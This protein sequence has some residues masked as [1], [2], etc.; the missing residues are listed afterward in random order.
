MGDCTFNTNP[1][2]IQEGHKACALSDNGVDYQQGMSNTND[3]IPFNN[4]KDYGLKTGMGTGDGGYENRAEDWIKNAGGASDRY[5]YTDAMKDLFAWPNSADVLRPGTHPNNR[6]NP[7]DD[8]ADGTVCLPKA[9]ENTEYP[10]FVRCCSDAVTA[11]PKRTGGRPN[12]AYPQDM[13]CLPC[14]AGYHNSAGNGKDFYTC[15]CGQPNVD[16]QG[17]CSG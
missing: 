12:P 15:T 17:N 9:D 16:G 4:V 13:Y 14:P 3:A 11:V 6:P 5:F 2:N 7:Y 10:V 1:D 8:A